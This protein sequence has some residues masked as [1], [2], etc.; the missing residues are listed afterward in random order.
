MIFSRIKSKTEKNMRVKYL[1]RKK[2]VEL[3]NLLPDS[4]TRPKV[5]ANRRCTTPPHTATTLLSSGKSR[6]H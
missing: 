6:L 1:Q 4:T 3:R 2:N 5:V